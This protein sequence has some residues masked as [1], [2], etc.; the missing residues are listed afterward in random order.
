MMLRSIIDFLGL[1]RL[2]ICEPIVERRMNL[3]HAT[4][5]IRWSSD[6]SPI[7]SHGSTGRSPL[8]TPAGYLSIA[9]HHR[10]SSVD[11]SGSPVDSTALIGSS[12][13]TD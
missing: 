8:L 7:S 2:L 3:D 13:E 1:I 9:P 11:P 12:A 6:W 4:K 5:Q 10:D